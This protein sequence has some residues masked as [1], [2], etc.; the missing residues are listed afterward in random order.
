[1]NEGYLSETHLYVKK[2]KIFIDK[3]KLKGNF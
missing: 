2:N 3:R 1:M